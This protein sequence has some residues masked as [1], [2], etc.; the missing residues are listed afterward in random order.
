[1]I[2]NVKGIALYALVALT[3]AMSVRDN[4]P[5]SEEE[6]LRA[7][8]SVG[9]YPSAATALREGLMR[10]PDPT[11]GRLRAMRAQ[12]LAQAKSAPVPGTLSETVKDRMAMVSGLA[13]CLLVVVG[14]ISIRRLQGR[15]PRRPVVQKMQ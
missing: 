12:A 7:V 5:A 15:Q 6:I 10:E 4:L 9:G 8:A 1:M 13:A 2:K 3:L 11:K 14:R